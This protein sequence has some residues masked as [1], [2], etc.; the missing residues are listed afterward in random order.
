ML[1][2]FCVILICTLYWIYKYYTIYG[3][4]SLVPS[5]VEK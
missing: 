4:N 3:N 1:T 5:L 2:L